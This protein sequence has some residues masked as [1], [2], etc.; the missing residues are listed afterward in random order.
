MY[1]LSQVLVGVSDIFCLIAMLKKSKKNVAI[2]L[3]ISTILFAS[4]YMCLGGWTGAGICFVEIVFLLLLL[5]FEN[6]GLQKRVKYLALGTIAITITMSLLTWAG[7]ISLL[8]MIAMV[9]YLIG[10]I[11]PNVII[12][13]T[14]AFVRLF[15]NGIYML[16][17]KSY[18]GSALTIVL[19]IFTIVGIIN[20][21]KNKWQNQKN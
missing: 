13:K 8:P 19:L 21:S 18:F 20:D 12:V 2:Y 6:K 17:L 7:W 9:V 11:F 15:L 1:V 5:L 14:G 16:I 10:M 3:L 4:H